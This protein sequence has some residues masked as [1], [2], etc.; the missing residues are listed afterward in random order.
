MPAP[1][2]TD[3]RADLAGGGAAGGRGL[4]LGAGAATPFRLASSPFGRVASSEPI[5]CWP[6]PRLTFSA[7]GE[8]SAAA[9]ETVPASR[10]RSKG[11]AAALAAQPSPLGPELTVTELVAEI[12]ALPD[13]GVSVAGTGCGRR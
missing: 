2:P 8:C 10:E 7:N 9:L 12:G 3:D 1:A 11:R 13:H 4:R 6:S 5:S